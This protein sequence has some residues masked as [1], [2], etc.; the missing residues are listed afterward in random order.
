MFA[1]VNL[2]VCLVSTMHSNIIL[3]SGIN[4]IMVP[5]IYVSFC[6]IINLF[7]ECSFSSFTSR[8]FNDLQDV[9]TVHNP[10]LQVQFSV[11]VYSKELT[12][13]SSQSIV[14]MITLACCSQMC[15]SNRCKYKQVTVKAQHNTFRSQNYI[16]QTETNM[17]K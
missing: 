14:Y 8:S 7:T 4:I 2:H 5:S 1:Y 3:D 16:L 15:Q 17:H 10:C 12:T 13:G 11:G 6:F 9:S